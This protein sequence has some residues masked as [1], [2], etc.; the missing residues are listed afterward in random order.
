MLCRIEHCIPYHAHYVHSRHSLHEAQSI[1]VPL[2]RTDHVSGVSKT[3]I[4]TWKLTKIVKEY[5]RER[6]IVLTKP[7][8]RQDMFAAIHVPY[9]RPNINLPIE[10]S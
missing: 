2:P 3:A 9:F 1:A 6:A 4:R 10:T 5:K 7:V 8:E